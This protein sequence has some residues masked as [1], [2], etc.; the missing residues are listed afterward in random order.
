MKWLNVGGAERNYAWCWTLNTKMP[1]IYRH[2][3]LCECLRTSTDHI[4]SIV[5]RSPLISFHGT[6]TPRRTT[7]SFA[8]WKVASHWL[9]LWFHISDW[10]ALRSDCTALISLGLALECLCINYTGVVVVFSSSK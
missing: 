10:L 9:V 1:N 7:A 4:V 3:L 8:V 5:Y 2:Q 6:S